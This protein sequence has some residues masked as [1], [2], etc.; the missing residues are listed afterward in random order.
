MNGKPSKE[1][2]K[3]WSAAAYFFAAAWILA[4]TA[5]A[6]AA[7]VI[8]LSARN[9]PSTTG[10]MLTT[11]ASYATD[12]PATAAWVQLG[13]FDTANMLQNTFFVGNN[14]L[15]YVGASGARCLLQASLS[16]STNTSAT[17]LGFAIAING[18]V[19]YT[20]VTSFTDPTAANV[21]NVNFATLY[22]ASNGDTFEVW[23][24]SVGT[25]TTITTL[26]NSTSFIMF[27]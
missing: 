24:K 21:Q 20:T 16:F 10:Q 26:Q 13:G 4:V 11:L 3:G 18:A 1:A 9:E 19:D 12:L 14:E 23:A 22:Q 15:E 2:K 27:C 6:I 17:V 7:L 8:A 25:N 5:I